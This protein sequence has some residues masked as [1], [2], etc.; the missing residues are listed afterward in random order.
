MTLPE[1]N[2]SR[3]IA[4]SGL[5]AVFLALI[6]IQAIF[7]LSRWHY[8]KGI[9]SYETGDY[10]NA[11]D[12]FV[13]ANRIPDAQVFSVLAGRDRFRIQTAM[14]KTY[15]H[16]AGEA[17]TT[18]G[19]YDLLTKGAGALDQ[20]IAHDARSYRTTFW[21]AKVHTGLET[22]WPVLF[23]SG[24]ENPYNALPFYERAVS[25]R[26]TGYSI[27]Y[28]MIKY[29]YYKGDRGRIPGL[30]MHMAS[31]FP[32]SVTRLEKEPFYS[33]Q[34]R[35]KIRQGLLKALENG[36]SLRMTLFLL[37]Q[38]ALDDGA[39]D[40]AGAYYQ[41]G[42]AHQPHLNTA[43]TMIHMGMLLLRQQAYRDADRFFIKALQ[44]DGDFESAMMQIYK[45]FKS[46]QLYDGFVRFAGEV[47]ETLYFS[48]YIDFMVALCHTDA[49]KLELAKSL[50]NRLNEVNPE[51]RVYDL[52]AQVSQKQGNWD[53]MEIAARKATQLAPGNPDY[54][55]RFSMSL[56]A[57]KK[58]SR[59]EAAAT[60]AIVL[61]KPPA[62]WYYGHRAGIKKA[63]KQYRDAVADWERAL[64]IKPDHANYYYSIAMSYHALGRPVQALASINRAIGLKPENQ[65]FH[66]FK[67]KLLAWP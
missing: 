6:T 34:I 8:Q 29:L 24:D 14:G 13:L 61:S 64:E 36:V 21:A 39:V 10:D 54:Q 16:L 48:G 9:G 18:R 53:A 63:L 58:Y 56:A 65:A 30:V 66:S 37:S 32:L 44:L 22:V 55:I 3:I 59:A 46:E 35:E 1:N 57:Q 40:A 4:L 52:L 5:T 15:Y 27:H 43:G 12:S 42:L 67:K 28:D 25:L 47:Q 23:K 62:F 38:M 7:F 17:G 49:G 19:F 50:L 2:I 41:Q 60:K 26:P 45:V 11:L 20:A 31:I 51:A 33:D